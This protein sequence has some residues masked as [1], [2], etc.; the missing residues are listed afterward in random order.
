VLFDMGPTTLHRLLFVVHHLASDGVSWRILLE[1]LW[2]ACAQL[3]R[4]EAIQLS[5]KTTSFRRRAEQLAKRAQSPILRQE[6]PHW[7]AVGDGAVACLPCDLQGTV[8]RVDSVRVIRVTLTAAETH[9]LLHGVPG[10][11]ETQISEVL[12]TA[13]LQA[14]S[15]W[16]G[17]R[18]LL[19]DIEDHGREVLLDGADLSRTVG[20]FT[21]IFPVH[22][23][24]A[25]VASPGDALKSVKEQM[26]R[27]PHRGVGY[28]LLRY[29]STD[30]EIERDLRSRPQPEVS[31]NYL[32]QF[33][34][35]PSAVPRITPAPESSGPAR[36][37]RQTRRY[38]LEIDG[39]VLD[40][41]L[42]VEWMFSESIHRRST[43]EGLARNFV[44]ALRALIAYCQ[45]P[46][47][48]G[49][50]P[51]DFSRAKLSQETLDKLVA[52]V[53]RTRRGRGE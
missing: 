36:S 48:G 38:L 23:R 3:A 13:L 27:I 24:L 53:E 44:G 26:R 49:Y 51:S 29:L 46:E 17:E 50:T 15:E 18:S 7:L 32:G 12:L 35:I 14:F 8:N 5:P 11:Y 45:A 4:G 42:E 37:P 47:V 19:L 9:A 41:H 21:S 40:D 33:A 25:P 34:S 2:T 39:S 52:K 10:A 22:L 6:L 43:I 1:D 16:T 30:T 20:R 28:G 31:F